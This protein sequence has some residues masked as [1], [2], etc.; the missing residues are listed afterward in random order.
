MDKN[1]K[2]YLRGFGLIGLMFT[3]IIAGLYFN[4]HG[5]KKER[6]ELGLEKYRASQS[7]IQTIRFVYEAPIERIIINWDIESI[8]DILN[9]ENVSEEVRR[10]GDL[11]SEYANRVVKLNPEKNWD[12]HPIQGDT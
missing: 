4:V 6:K 11:F 7:A 8:L 2:E 12:Y 5:I 1:T 9:R 10:S 3:P